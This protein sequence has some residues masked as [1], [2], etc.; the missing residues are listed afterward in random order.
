MIAAKRPFTACGRLT[1]LV[2]ES[3]DSAR[4]ARVSSHMDVATV[5]FHSHAVLP[6]AIWRWAAGPGKH[7]PYRMTGQIRRRCVLAGKQQH[8]E[9]D[10]GWLM[11]AQRHSH[12]YL[13]LSRCAHQ[14]SKTRANR[15][16]CGEFCTIFGKNSRPYWE[17][18]RISDALEIDCGPR[19]YGNGSCEAFQPPPTASISATLAC[20][21]LD[22]TASAVCSALRRVVCAVITLL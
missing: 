19:S 10:V 21:R 14:K 13:R 16:A 11:N 4:S 1:P 6:W 18:I 7:F 15:P 2:G 12:A 20:R 22:S 9:T 3:N 17:Y 5:A 8:C